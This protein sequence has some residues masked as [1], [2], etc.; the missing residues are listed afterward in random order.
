MQMLDAFLP[1]RCVRETL[2][3]G[4]SVAE[5]LVRAHLETLVRELELARAAVV[6]SVAALR[7][8]NCELDADVAH[9]LQRRVGDVIGAEIEKAQA[10]LDR[11]Q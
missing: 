8:Q 1:A 2:P 7:H 9:M 5:S 11:L 4:G 10:L 6:T 3:P